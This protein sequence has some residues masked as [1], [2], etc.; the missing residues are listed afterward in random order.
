M[1]HIEP[2]KN[3]M[4]ARPKFGKWLGCVAMDTAD[5]WLVCGGGPSL[6]L[7]HL[8]SLTATAVF[9]TPG[10]CQ[11]CVMFHDDSIISAGSKG[12]VNHW[13]VN[14]ERRMEI[15]CTPTSVFSLSFNYTSN[16]YKVLSA[17]GN[18][19]K[20]DIFTNFG[21]KAFSFTFSQI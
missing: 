19:S 4:C 9:D 13:S 7:W 6:S 16:S 1:L 14:G 10:T 15:P 2:Y 12:V 21:Y 18:S 11:K 20:V 3:E 17:T 8:R 5:D